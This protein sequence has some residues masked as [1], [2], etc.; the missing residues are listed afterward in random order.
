V[1]TPISSKQIALHSKPLHGLHL[2]FKPGA[3]QESLPRELQNCIR[4]NPSP[5]VP[6][7][8]LL[9]QS[10]GRRGEYVNPT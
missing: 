2:F 10:G 1:K 9:P 4:S 3:G 5:I 8:I 6:A 7:V